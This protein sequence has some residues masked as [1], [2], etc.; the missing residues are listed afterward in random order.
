[1]KES[2]TPHETKEYLYHILEQLPPRAL[3][4]VTRFV[5]G[6]RAS[7][8]QDTNQDDR[9]KIHAEARAF[10]AMHRQ[11]MEKHLGWYVAIHEGQLVDDDQ[12][13]RKL[14][15]R[16]RAKYGIVPVLIRQVAKAP[17]REF[18]ILS[19]WLERDSR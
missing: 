16:I 12:D 6:L 14:Y 11:L 8:L 18:N 9:A 4:E 3:S 15:L 1:M 19:P 13:R 5:E 10:R 17:E 2:S 7:A